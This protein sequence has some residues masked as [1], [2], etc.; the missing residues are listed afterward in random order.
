MNCLSKASKNALEIFVGKDAVPD[1]VLHH[2]PTD[3]RLRALLSFERLLFG[4]RLL[5]QLMHQLRALQRRSY[6]L[7]AQVTSSIGLS[8]LLR[9][10]APAV[11]RMFQ[12][13]HRCLST[14]EPPQSRRYLI[15]ADCSSVR[16]SPL[17]RAAQ[18]LRIARVGE[19]FLGI[20]GPRPGEPPPLPPGPPALPYATCARL[21]SRSQ[22]SGPQ[23][24]LPL[25]KRS[26][27]AWYP[28]S[29]CSTIDMRGFTA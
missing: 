27:R 9:A 16:V 7:R 24:I 12:L 13:F 18:Q 25:R 5:G 28:C 26:G 19:R 22:E 4:A 10:I 21:G 20:F 2:Q 1:E 11:Q 3:R 15:S 14:L 23:P 6:S 29:H 17:Q 8:K